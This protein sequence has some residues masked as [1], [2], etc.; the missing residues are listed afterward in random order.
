MAVGYLFHLI[1]VHADEARH[2]HLLSRPHIDNVVATLEGAL[3]D[4]DVGELTKPT[5]LKRVVIV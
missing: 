2:F 5:S 4:T 1:A 3:V